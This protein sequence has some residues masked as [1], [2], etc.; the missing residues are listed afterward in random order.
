ML[1]EHEIIGK[2]IK[3]RR[4]LESVH[5]FKIIKNRYTY[6]RKASPGEIFMVIGLAKNLLQDKIVDEIE[7]EHE[8]YFSSNYNFAVIDDGEIVSFGNSNIDDQGFFE[9]FEVL[10]DW[11]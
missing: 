10:E 11:V 8:D 6:S 5:I 4:G 3:V 2:L 1:K 9:S 7:Y